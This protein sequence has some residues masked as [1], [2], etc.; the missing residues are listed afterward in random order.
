MKMQDSKMTDQRNVKTR[1]TYVKISRRTLT[2][3]FVIP[4]LSWESNYRRITLNLTNVTR[5]SGN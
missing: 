2:V 5:C 3:H 4:A 1:G